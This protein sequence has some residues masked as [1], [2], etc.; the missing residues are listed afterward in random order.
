MT[1]AEV[2]LQWF[3]HD[4]IGFKAQGRKSVI[5]PYIQSMG[6]TCVPR[7]RSGHRRSS[8]KTTF[9]RPE[10]SYRLYGGGEAIQSEAKDML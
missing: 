10:L 9:Y 8:Y 1:D 3:D 7:I 5:H 4:Q 6:A 2:V